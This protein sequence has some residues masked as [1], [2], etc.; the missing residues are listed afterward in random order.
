MNPAIPLKNIT[1]ANRN[2]FMKLAVWEV[3]IQPGTLLLACTSPIFT[4]T[5]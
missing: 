3:M 4:L 1:I 2:T 5:K